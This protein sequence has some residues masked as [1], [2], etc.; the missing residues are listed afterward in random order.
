MN[1]GAPAIKPDLNQ[2]NGDNIDADQ[3]I[4]ASTARCNHFELPYGH[5]EDAMRLKRKKKK[6]R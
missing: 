4:A 3:L 6:K 5:G 1:A 2:A